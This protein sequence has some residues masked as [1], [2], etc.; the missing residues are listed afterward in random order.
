M[1]GIIIT[2]WARIAGVI[3]LILFGNLQPLYGS[4]D[5]IV[6]VK[7]GNNSYYDQTI[8]S[9]IGRVE[10]ALSFQVIDTASIDANSE[11]LLQSQRI[12]ALGLKAVQRV[13]ERLPKKYVIG[14][15][16]TQQQHDQ[17]QFS[18][19]NHLT[20]LLDQP[21]A[22]YLA[23]TRFLFRPKSVG[24]IN[25]SPVELNRH[26]LNVLKRLKLE[27]NQYQ[28]DD[29]R[30]L[31]GRVRR[32]VKHNDALLMLPEQ[33]IYNRNT[34]KGILL[35]AYRARIPVISY[36]PAH[37]TSGA[38]ASI[39]SSPADIGRHLADILNSYG[40]ISPDNVNNTQF[41]RYYS[42]SINSRVAHAL[43]ID[44]PAETG[45]SKY[46]SEAIE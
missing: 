18:D 12:I 28:S 34:L 11:L 14:A 15:Y 16:L 44:I 8:E 6:I 4:S 21:L 22:R 26:Q 10:D 35:T 45:L 17:L 36:S 7:S 2:G 20:V 3:L 46:L 23:F 33:G 43:G 30:K 31:L 1:N 9:L 5:R 25:H 40:K 29:S 39:Y 32:L 19:S 37:V 24:I 42:V 27:L 38:L 41:A 13:S